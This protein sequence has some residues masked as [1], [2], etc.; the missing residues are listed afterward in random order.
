MT[1]RL[2]MS[3][4]AS[5]GAVLTGCALFCSA[6]A[7]PA[8][9]DNKGATLEAPKD[10][11]I[12]TIR[13]KISRTNGPDR[14]DFDMRMLAA[15]PQHSFTTRTPWDKSP[16][17]FT[18]P[19]LRDVLQLVGANGRTILAVA[20][21]DYKVELPVDDT[22]QFDVVLARLMDDQPMRV[23]DRGPLFIVYPYDSFEQLRTD[24]Y[25]SRSAWQLRSL[26]IL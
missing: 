1:S 17:K 26:D 5:L 25:I 16:R 8:S 20:L 10:K 19:K 4:R 12:L 23:R 15:L 13:G 11:V 18:G 7:A 3:R 9:S 6:W 22:Q 14:A 2:S 21:N 24:R